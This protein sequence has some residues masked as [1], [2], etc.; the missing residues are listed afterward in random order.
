MMV[1]RSLKYFLILFFLYL[2]VWSI[3]TW[4]C[5]FVLTPGTMTLDLLLAWFLHHITRHSWY[6]DTKE[7]YVVLSVTESKVSRHMGEATSSYRWVTSRF[8]NCVLSTSVI[9]IVTHY[10]CYLV[11]IRCVK[12]IGHMEQSVTPYTWWGSPL[13]IHGGRLHVPQLC[14]SDPVHGRLSETRCI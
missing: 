8:H 4:C 2:V 10:S 7:R 5:N 13:G 1:V 12:T 14:Q 6:P 11:Y 9:D 3:L